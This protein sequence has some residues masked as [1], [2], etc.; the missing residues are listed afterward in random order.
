MS[1]GNKIRILLSVGDRENTQMYSSGPEIVN[2]NPTIQM[3]QANELHL[4]VKDSAE[5]IEHYSYDFYATIQLVR[6]EAKT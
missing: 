1:D 4:T 2:H 5:E 6:S 3:N